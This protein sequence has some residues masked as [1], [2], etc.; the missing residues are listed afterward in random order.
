[1][2]TDALFPSV[3]GARRLGNSGAPPWALCDVSALCASLPN[4]ALHI[5]HFAHTIPNLAF[6]IRYLGVGA[7]SPN[8]E[9]HSY[10]TLLRIFTT[11]A[12]F[13]ACFCATQGTTE[14]W[15]LGFRI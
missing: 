12:C 6:K 14:V 8:V 15:G 4:L 11:F 7:D 9:C 2:E 10:G 13:L 1:M 5:A 3:G